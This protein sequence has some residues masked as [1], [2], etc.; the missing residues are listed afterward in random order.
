MI[1]TDDY[2][3]I[4]KAFLRESLEFKA[5]KINTE[6]LE[7]PYYSEIFGGFFNE[8]S[9]LKSRKTWDRI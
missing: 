7:I 2:S 9:Y 3:I 8:D 5:Q 6:K 1:K 4:F